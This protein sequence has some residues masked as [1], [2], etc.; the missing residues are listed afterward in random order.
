MRR[1]DVAWPLPAEDGRW[2]G[3]EDVRTQPAPARMKMDIACFSE[4]PM[5]GHLV[6]PLQAGDGGQGVR[7]LETLTRAQPF[8]EVDAKCAGAPF[9]K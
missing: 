7:C 8:L 9:S 3:R 5:M 2:Q 4:T 1:E 6:S